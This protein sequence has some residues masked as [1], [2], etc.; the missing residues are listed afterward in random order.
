MAIVGGGNVLVN[1]VD[2]QVEHEPSDEVLAQLVKVF[3]SVFEVEV[4]HIR[5]TRDTR[6]Q[7]IHGRLEDA[8][9]SLDT[10]SPA[11]LSPAPPRNF[12]LV[13]MSDFQRLQVETQIAWEL[14]QPS[15]RSCGITFFSS[16]LLLPPCSGRN[17]CFL[18]ITR[19]SWEQLRVQTRDEVLFSLTLQHLK[20]AADLALLDFVASARIFSSSVSPT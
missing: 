20:L 14:L 8:E 7:D 6:A 3:R 13:V 17:V 9:I 15:K 16:P 5:C 12:R 2:S 10:N 4:E 19:Y 18:L 11:P 1:L